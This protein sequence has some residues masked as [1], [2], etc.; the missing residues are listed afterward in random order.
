MGAGASAVPAPSDDGLKQKKP[1]RSVA[2]EKSLTMVGK[3]LRDAIET[4][5]LSVFRASDGM[6]LTGEYTT[7]LLWGDHSGLQPATSDIYSH[8]SV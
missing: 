6:W 3:L 7:G 4:Q 2:T 1:T 8:Q 5:K